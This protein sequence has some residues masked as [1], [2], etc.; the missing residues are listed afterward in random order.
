[1]GSKSATTT[2][3]S[4][5][6]QAAEGEVIYGPQS[7]VSLPGS[8]NVGEGSS[9][10]ITGSSPLDPQKTFEAVL[11]NSD[12]TLAKVLG[13]TGQLAQGLFEQ[14]PGGAAAMTGTQTAGVG[15]NK[16]IVV[17]LVIVGLLWLSRGK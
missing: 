5:L 1:M 6:R 11:S 3:I 17:G 10:T 2:T 7:R 16:A 13:V 15:G 8:W 14:T 12:S 9:V 4:D